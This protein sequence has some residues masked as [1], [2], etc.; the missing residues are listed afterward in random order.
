MK[1]AAPSASQASIFAAPALS[2]TV[3]DKA[4]TLAAAWPEADPGSVAVVHGPVI[5]SGLFAWGDGFADPAPE[6]V[7]GEDGLRVTLVAHGSAVGLTRAEPS[8]PPMVA[9][10]MRPV[11]GS[12]SSAAFVQFVTASA[13]SLGALT[14]LALPCEYTC[15]GG[16]SQTG[17]ACGILTLGGS[18]GSG[19]P[20]CWLHCA[21]AEAM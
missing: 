12:G 7:V 14:L 5:V 13:R 17:G 1:Y 20:R 19:S 16:S 9:F 3:L 11:D 2:P 4:R 15:E 10:H 18:S 6:L 21:G 8:R